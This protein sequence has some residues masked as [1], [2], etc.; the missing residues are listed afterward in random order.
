M[1]SKTSH[2]GIAAG[3]LNIFFFLL[4]YN[5]NI[6]I[7]ANNIYVV[8]MF[9][10]TI[11]LMI[12]AIVNVS[13]K[14]EEFSIREGLKTGIGVILLGGI[15]FWVYQMIHAYFIE[16]DLID[17]LA[18]AMVDD[19]KLNEQFS[20]E[21]VTQKITEYKSRFKF[22]LFSS[23]VLKSLFTGFFVSLITSL[24]IKAFYKR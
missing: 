12:L 6:H 3:L 4:Q 5:Q 2:F 17:K 21:Q 14:S 20:P 22:N 15:I 8:I 9:I 10:V 16:T 19:L 23:A 7:E 24:V 1:F 13:K 18:L 11:V